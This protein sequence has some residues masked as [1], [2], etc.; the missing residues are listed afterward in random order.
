MI[1]AVL[2]DFDGVLVDTEMIS[3]ALFKRFLESYHLTL[4]KSEY[5]RDFPGRMLEHSLQRL[6]DV[7]ELPC[8]LKE[9]V[10]M[11]RV[12]EKEYMQTYGVSLK[13]GV[14]DLLAYLKSEGIR[15]CIA[16]S[17]DR[18]RC[19]QM[20]ASYDLVK[21]FDDLTFGYEVAHGKP[22][23]DIYLLACEKLAVTPDEALV[24]EDSEAG[25][26]SA[27][28]ACIPVICI[29]DMKVPDT[30]YLRKTAAVYTTLHDVITYI[31][32]KKELEA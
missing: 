29:P 22:A 31:E 30:K 10:K 20:L 12:F 3:Y 4:T 21:D 23:P 16:S 2:F 25:I 32:A 8:T 24:I 5:V 11:I 1:K 13:P 14:K 7:H 9:A 17:S 19:L 28:D 6:I 15:T 27:F 26:Q 18:Q